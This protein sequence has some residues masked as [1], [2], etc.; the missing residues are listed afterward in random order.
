M[1]FPSSGHD[2][3]PLSVLKCSVQTYYKG[4]MP[5]TVPGYVIGCPFTK[6]LTQSQEYGDRA[7][8][9]SVLSEPKEAH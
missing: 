4:A 6:G 3:F 5:S 1:L 2:P 7:D 8:A 9:Q